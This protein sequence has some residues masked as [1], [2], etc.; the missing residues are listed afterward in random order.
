M[1]RVL[2]GCSP[3]AQSPAIGLNSTCGLPIFRWDCPPP[4]RPGTADPPLHWLVRQGVCGNSP[5]WVTAPAVAR[6]EGRRLADVPSRQAERARKRGDSAAGGQLAGRLQGKGESPRRRPPLVCP[7]RPTSKRR[8]RRS[9]TRH[10]HGLRVLMAGPRAQP[11]ALA[12]RDGARS[13]RL[14]GRPT[15]HEPGKAIL[16]SAA[17]LVKGLAPRCGEFLP[18]AMGSA[19]ASYSRRPA[20]SSASSASLKLSTRAI[21]EPLTRKV[22]ASGLSAWRPLDRPVALIRPRATT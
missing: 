7:P 8:G 17:S 16:P 9:Q 12:A 18:H 14:G 5:I 3:R 11:I 10:R 4:L 19:R 6:W 2:R 20:A 22:V 15:P 21:W 1:V 13:G